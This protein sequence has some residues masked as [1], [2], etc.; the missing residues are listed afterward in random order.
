MLKD[1]KK[2]HRKHFKR[3]LILWENLQLILASFWG[4]VG[5][6]SM[7]SDISQ[8]E[9]WV[10]L[11]IRSEFFQARTA[12]HQVPDEFLDLSC[13]CTINSLHWGI[14]FVLV[15]SCSCWIHLSNLLENFCLDQNCQ[16]VTKISHNLASRLLGSHWDK[17]KPILSFQWVGQATQWLLWKT[18]IS[19]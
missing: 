7:L 13:Y 1:S 14:F 6:Y 5:R 15:L 11:K 4:V 12:R 17:L 9:L 10:P 2:C 8:K 16:A 19:K 18:L 3:P